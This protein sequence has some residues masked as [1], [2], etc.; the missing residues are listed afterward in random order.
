MRAQG[1]EPNEIVRDARI[2]LG[3]REGG[4]FGLRQR[5]VGAG[6]GLE[7]DRAVFQGAPRVE[8][9]VRHVHGRARTDAGG[10]GHLAVGLEDHDAELAAQQHDGLVLGGIE[11]AMGPDVGVR[12]HGVEEPLA[13]IVARGV[14]VEVLAPAGNSGGLGG[15][16][17][18]K[19]GIEDADACH[20][21]E[22]L[23]KKKA[24]G[25]KSPAAGGRAARITLRP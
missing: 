17:V 14:E 2:A 18:E 24:A 16:P 12:A 9:V 10:G 21:T 13:G 20:R 25:K 8:G 7:E 11:M 19:G 1:F 23:A 15:E 6:F 4:H 5:D 3:R 22:P